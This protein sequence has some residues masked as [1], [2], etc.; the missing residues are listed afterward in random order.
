MLLRYKYIIIFLTVFVPVLHA[1]GPQEAKV[2]HKK[3]EREKKKKDKAAQK[4]YDKA[5]K[6]H[7]KHQTPETRAMMKSSKKAAK[8]TLPPKH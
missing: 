8:K 2:N 3:I 6:A 7:M 5:V 1:S 4:E